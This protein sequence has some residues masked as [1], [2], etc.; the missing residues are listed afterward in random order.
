MEMYEQIIFISKK[1]FG[2]QIYSV[3]TNFVIE[4]LNQL[5]TSISSGSKELVREFED[6]QTVLVKQLIAQVNYTLLSITFWLMLH[7]PSESK[8]L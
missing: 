2:Q 3:T 1:I 6:L 4:I 7:F 8:N 5:K